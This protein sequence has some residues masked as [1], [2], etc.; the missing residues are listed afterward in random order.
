M[1]KQ[2][3]YLFNLLL[4]VPTVI[5]A[6]T[7]TIHIYNRQTKLD[8]PFAIVRFGAS[9]YG[10]IS[11]YNG[12]FTFLS[13]QTKDSNI[14]FFEITCL[15][16]VIQRI[17]IPEHDTAIYLQ[18]DEHTLDEITI[19]PP[20]EKIRRILNNAIE[21]KYQ[22][23]P[24]KYE[25]YQCHV[26]YK[27]AVDAQVPDPAEA[28]ISEET[29]GMRKLLS[30][31][32]LLLSETYSIRT[33][34]KPD[35]LQE[36][37]L[38][39]RLSGFKKSMFTSMVT[40]V[41]PFHA[42]TDYLTVNGQDYH[43]PVSKGY[44]Q[45]YKFNLSDEVLQGIDT[46]WVLSFAP[47]KASEYEMSG[48]VFI[49]SDGYAIANF[50]ANVKDTILDRTVTLEQQ[51]EKVVYDEH[52]KKWFPKH[53]NYTINWVIRS[54]KKTLP[55]K[56][57]G[58]SDIDS[59]NFNVVDFGFN[60]K[61]TIRIDEHANQSLKM[62]ELRMQQLT[63]KDS[64]SYHAMDSI[65]E[66]KHFDKSMDLFS[67]IPEWRIPVKGFDI[68]LKDIFAY[69][70]YEGVRLGL[71]LRTNEKIVKWLSVGAY[72]CYGFSDAHW[73]YGGFAELY[74]D[75]YKETALKC[76]YTNDI[77]DPGR[78]RINT[79]LDKNYLNAYL[80]TRVDH[81]TSY[82]TSIKKKFGYWNIELW[83]RR[84]YIVP[85]YK[86]VF[87]NNG[88]GYAA[89]NA[90]EVALNMRYAFGERTAPFYGVYYNMPN[91]YP[92][93]YVKIVSGVLDSGKLTIPYIQAVAA[94]VWHKHINRLGYEHILVAGGKS[95]SENTLPISKLFAGTGYNYNSPSYD[96]TPYT[97][98]GMMT[99]TPY[100]FYSDQF[101]SLYYCHDFD[102]KLYKKQFGT[103]DL[104]SAPNISLQYNLLYGKLAQRAAH[105]F[106]SFSVPDPAYQE[107]GLILKNILRVK[108]LG[109]YYLTV[110]LG[111][112][113]NLTQ[114]GNI[115]STGRTVIG[116][117][118]EF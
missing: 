66:R 72:G 70:E 75:K 115:L 56:M 91:K 30:N 25:R 65:G 89:Y 60:K 51:Y 11:N 45:Y 84:E 52:G 117:G 97:F 74:L 83:G 48:K 10:A 68:D 76:S 79:E 40:D 6:Q 87:I 54:D 80:M 8:I 105:E 113:C 111:Y 112:F 55:I 32:H 71:G 26:Y 107:A 61:H 118:F 93:C 2:F 67:K 20:F 73:K 13:T 108:Y 82:Y 90:K 21:H 81:V 19:K 38:A 24:D 14:D 88:N 15:G 64:A 4:I 114:S 58:T 9:G 109:V 98:G 63:E 34:Q 69:N 47:K 53:L 92:V 1:S 50:V 101:I 44:E 22:N 43:N 16:Y 102:W 5:W 46:I 110:D 42:Y 99:I 37:V 39:T 96:P 33:W 12:E 104:S 28:N 86:Y 116:G 95:V 27:M 78:V 29:A 31:K 36:D 49:N 85:Q 41:L 18:P 57:F 62:N 106:V 94:M 7:T 35:Q 17:P 103:S 3:L 59:V 100:Q 77:S 23:N